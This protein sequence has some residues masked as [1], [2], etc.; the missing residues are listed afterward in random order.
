MNTQYASTQ[1]ASERCSAFVSSYARSFFNTPVHRLSVHQ[2]P[3]SSNVPM[4][5]GSFSGALS[6]VQEAFFLSESRPLL[7]HH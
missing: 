1:V 2:D 4:R 3:S 6:S 5:S 7:G